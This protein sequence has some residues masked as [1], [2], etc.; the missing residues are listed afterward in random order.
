MTNASRRNRLRW[1]VLTL[2]ALEVAAGCWLGAQVRWV[3]QREAFLART[4]VTDSTGRHANR[5]APPG[6]L[7]VLGAKGVG[8]LLVPTEAEMPVAESLFPE[9][10]VRQGVIFTVPMLR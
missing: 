8:Q 2:L 7:Q 5:P 6:I 4:C 1:V 10:E 9:A 3:R